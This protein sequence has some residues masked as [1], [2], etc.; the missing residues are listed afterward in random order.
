MFIFLIAI[1]LPEIYTITW[2]VI[3]NARA[4]PQK[5]INEAIKLTIRTRVLVEML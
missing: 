1:E 4:V 3:R 5:M 2:N